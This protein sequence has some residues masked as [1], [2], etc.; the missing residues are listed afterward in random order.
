M[1]TLTPSIPD[2]TA[3]MAQDYRAQYSRWPRMKKL[4]IPVT[5]LLILAATAHATDPIEGLWKTDKGE[6]VEVKACAQG[7][8]L[9]PRTGK[10]A[11]MLVGTMAHDDKAYAGT[12]TDPADGKTYEGSAKVSGNKLTLKGC[13]MRVVCKAQTWMRASG[14]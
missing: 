2:P 14:I 5:G 13:V 9:I 6:S 7:Y 10:H 3:H 12:V 11:G 4:L 8:C 1:S